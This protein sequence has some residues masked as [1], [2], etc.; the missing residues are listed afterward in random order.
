ME[1]YI[2]GSLLDFS[3]HCLHHFHTLL[4]DCPQ[5]TLLPLRGLHCCQ[6]TR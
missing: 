2:L 5:G 1:H 6:H 4:G 3:E